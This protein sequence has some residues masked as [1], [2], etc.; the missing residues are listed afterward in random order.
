MLEKY[1]DIFP[2]FYSDVNLF[3]KNNKISHAYLIEVANY[4]DYMKVI[5]SLVVDILNIYDNGRNIEYEKLIN[6]NSYSDFFIVSPKESRWIKK[7][8]I[9]DLQSAYKTKS[10]YNNKKIYIIDRADEMNLASSNT[11]LKFLEEP[12]DDV[13]AILI[14]RNKYNVLPTIIS[15]C[16][17]LKL[18]M[19][20]KDNDDDILN[21]V[22]M[23]LKLVTNK[24]C[25]SLP[26]I[27]K[28]NYDFEDR[29]NLELFVLEIIKCYHDVYRYILGN[30]LLYYN[31]YVE[32][33]DYIAKNIDVGDIS[34][35]II[36]VEE[37]YE[38]LKFNVNTRLF[39]D[40][41]VM[42]LVGVDVDV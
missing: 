15:R 7:E 9:L 20:V 13:V 39:L 2:K 25:N 12:V 36:N 35:I 6:N 33:L 8:Q 1:K 3:V 31:N 40:K 14:T 28:I 38:N 23:F 26:Y 21:K 30:K 24:K 10:V 32:D 37:L 27:K 4:D 34:K 17:L 29:E 5:K 19:V 41:I 11:L 18:D 16:Q 22:I 42:C